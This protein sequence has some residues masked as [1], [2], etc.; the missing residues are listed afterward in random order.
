MVLMRGRR[1]G[2]A[3]RA[4]GLCSFP[5]PSVRLSSSL[6]CQHGFRPSLVPAGLG[7]RFPEKE[8][9][10]P[11]PQWHGRRAGSRPGP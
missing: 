1:T 9:L 10:W 5:L 2:C 4:P 6:W 3:L 11:E 7:A 8:G